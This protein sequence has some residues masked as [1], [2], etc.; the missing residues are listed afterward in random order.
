[1]NATVEKLNGLLA[2]I[3]KNRRP[4]IASAPI[5]SAPRAAKNLFE[6]R[7]GENERTAEFA[8]RVRELVGPNPFPVETSDVLPRMTALDARALRTNEAEIAQ[9]LA[10]ARAEPTSDVDYGLASR[11]APSLSDD[12]ATTGVVGDVLA[13]DASFDEPEVHIGEVDPNEASMMVRLSE[14][15]PATDSFDAPVAIPRDRAI[16]IVEDP[17]DSP[18]IQVEISMSVAPAASDAAEPARDVIQVQPDAFAARDYRESQE[19]LEPTAYPERQSFDRM[20]ND[21]VTPLYSGPPTGHEHDIEIDDPEPVMPSI[22]IVPETAQSIPVSIEAP[23][24]SAPAQSV[25]SLVEAVGDEIAIPS[26]HAE[27]PI[28]R[29]VQP[30]SHAPATFGAFLRRAL[31]VRP[32]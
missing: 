2:R 27:G 19:S 14:L 23:A 18:E 10:P 32:H 28:M 12:G 30:S 6:L 29:V 17:E 16:N 1:M 21:A 4:L 26:V 8:A 25:S 3:Q 11:L 24:Y 5:E 20:T 15:S 22:L 13:D 9:S 31:S 7:D